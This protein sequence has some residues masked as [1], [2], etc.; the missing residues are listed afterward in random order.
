MGGL[1]GESLRKLVRQTASGPEAPLSRGE[2]S[3]GDLKSLLRG[4]LEA[5]PAAPA[6][7]SAPAAQSLLR[8]AID[9]LESRQLH[10]AL[11]RV[12]GREAMLSMLL[13]FADAE[14]VEVRWSH[15][16]EVAPDGRRA[17][18]VVELHTNSS[19][20]GQVWMRTRISEGVEVD[21]VMWA[22]QAELAARARSGS[23]SLATWLGE[24]GLRMTSLQVIHGPRPALEADAPLGPG[25]GAGRLVDLQA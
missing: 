9:D 25:L 17:P 19:R 13:P 11:E 24:A 3:G 21:L 20:F 12:E 10:A 14:P 7:E 16:R 4:L 1:T 18:W 5:M 15:A 23:S 22:E 2:P 8:E 6:A